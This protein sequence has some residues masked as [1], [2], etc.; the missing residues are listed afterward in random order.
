MVTILNW[1]T[2]YSHFHLHSGCLSASDDV[3]M[4]PVSVS[5]ATLRNA[6]VMVC[7]DVNDMPLARLV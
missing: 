7:S 6:T 4:M 1:T 2:L 5:M 3:S